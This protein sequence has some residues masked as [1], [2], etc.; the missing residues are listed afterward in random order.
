MNQSS[1]CLALI[2]NNPCQS[3]NKYTVGVLLPTE[4]KETSI[5][6]TPPYCENIRFHG[7]LRDK[8]SH[9]KLFLCNTDSSIIRMLIQVSL[10]SISKSSPVKKFMRSRQDSKSSR[11]QRLQP[12]LDTILTTQATFCSRC[13]KAPLTLLLS[14]Q[15]L[16][17]YC[18]IHMK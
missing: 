4:L 17:M 5:I 11:Q 1:L 6:Q 9:I 12:C 16:F 18:L 2:Q 8:N 3:L 14:M 13:S 15:S 7:S 10:L